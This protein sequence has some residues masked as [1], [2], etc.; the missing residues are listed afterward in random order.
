MSKHLIGKT[1]FWAVLA[2]STAFAL[3]AMAEDPGAETVLAT[4]NGVNITL[5]DLI[6][7]R[8]GLPEQYKALPD[9]VL[10]KG[11][12]DQL[13]QQEALMQSLAKS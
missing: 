4:V 5:G 10:F 3:P 9:D 13:V 12:L 6:V 8:D 7:T 11:I 2:L 1:R